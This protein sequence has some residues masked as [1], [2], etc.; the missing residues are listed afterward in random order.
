[1]E[2]PDREFPYLNVEEILIHQNEMPFERSGLANW[3]LTAV[4]L[5]CETQLYMNAPTRELRGF[6][7]YG[8]IEWKKI[9]NNILI[10]KF[11]Y[12]RMF[13]RDFPLAEFRIAT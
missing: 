13:W 2:C 10:M 5:F 7:R 4:H 9:K 8:K 6:Q 11:N 12:G 3:I 1:M